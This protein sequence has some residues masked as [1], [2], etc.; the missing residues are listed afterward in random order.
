M[1]GLLDLVHRCHGFT[2]GGNPT[3]HPGGTSFVRVQLD[4][5]DDGAGDDLLER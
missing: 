3:S 5:L 1:T 4:G 2:H